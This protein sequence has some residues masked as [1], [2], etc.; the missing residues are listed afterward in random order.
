MP[1]Q[2]DPVSVLFEPA[3]RKFYAGCK[4]KPGEWF[5]IRI[6]D[7]E[8]RHYVLFEIMGADPL[9][10]PDRAKRPGGLDARDRW[11]RGFVRALYRQARGGP[12]LEVQVSRKM[13]RRGVIPPGRFVRGRV[14]TGKQA[15]A[16]RKEQ[17]ITANP[18]N[19]ADPSIRDW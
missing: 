13:P 1:G 5:G 17:R 8:P 18:A 10:G 7:P 12:P 19:R 14:L 6:V 11:R 9:L 2:P 3:A 4:S 16:R 15:A